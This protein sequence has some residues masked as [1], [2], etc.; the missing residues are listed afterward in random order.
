MLKEELK[1]VLEE[2]AS[3][4]DKPLY[5]VGGAV[6]NILLNYAVDDIDLAAAL[7]PDKVI[8]ALRSTPFKVKVN[9]KKLFTLAIIKDGFRF[10][11][12][13]FRTDSY[14]KGFHR[15]HKSEFTEDLTQ[16]ALRRD[17]TANAVYYDIL[18]KKLIDPLNGAED[19]KKRILKTVT[20]PQEVFGQDG[21][22]LMRLARQ[23]AELGFEVEERTFNAAEDNAFLI[24][25]IAPERI[26]DEFNKI[27]S[28]DCRYGNEGGHVKGLRYLEKLGLLPFI[29]P[30]LVKCKGIKQRR[31]YHKYDVYGHVTKAYELAPTHIRLAA[32]FHDI[33]KP[34]CIREDGSMKGH[35]I[36][37]QEVAR[38]I[39]GRLRYS[40]DEINKTVRLVKLH[41][42][43]LKCDKE[44]GELKSFVQE[45]HD[46]IQDLIAL[47]RADYAASGNLKG[48]C[49][50][51]AR[52]EKIYQEMVDKKIPFTVKDLKVRGGDLIEMGIPEAKRG[53]LLE[54]LLKAAINEDLLSRAAQL[55]YLEKNK[56][57]D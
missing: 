55:E 20:S 35:D 39:M 47:K 57:K 29:L 46:I 3:L 53:R 45:N 1:A 12:T 44:S 15:P 26:R 49:L 52:L 13:S 9:S 48:D 18:E 43:D 10:E 23:A 32:L 36:K 21:L 17:F 27:V 37:G 31:D 51:A 33:A 34:L 7:P 40:N 5:M 4:F 6:R 42:Y 56:N 25:D 30:E 22:R 14:K 28:A 19:I 16:D 11:Y 41:M 24:Q 50:C 54:K 2:L 8:A 38:Q